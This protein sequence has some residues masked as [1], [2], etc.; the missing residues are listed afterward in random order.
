MKYCQ[1]NI[2]HLEPWIPYLWGLHLSILKN[3]WSLNLSFKDVF[4]NFPGQIWIPCIEPSSRSTGWPILNG[5][6]YMYNFVPYRGK[7]NTSIGVTLCPGLQIDNDTVRWLSVPY[8]EGVCRK[9]NSCL[10]ERCRS[11]GSHTSSHSHTSSLP[12]MVKLRVRSVQKRV[13]KYNA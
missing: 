7:L 5:W 9:R 6:W 13:T 2:T 11:N 1:F 3:F 12:W 4:Y 8:L 10:Q